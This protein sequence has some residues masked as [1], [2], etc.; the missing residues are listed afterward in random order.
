M[1]K[2]AKS[3]K[4]LQTAKELPLIIAEYYQQCHEA[5]K[6]GRPVG[7]MPPMNGAIEL[8]YAMDLQPVFPENWSP[9]CAAFGLTHQN[10]ATCENMGYS[11][12]L[13]GYLRNII[14]YVHGMMG[15]PANPLGGLPEPDII[16]PPQGGC[17][18]VMKIFQA[19]ERRFPR[20]KSFHADCPQV[21]IENIR[22]HHIDYAVGEMT[23]LVEFLT[24]ATGHR[25]DMDRLKEVV[26]LSDRACELWDEIMSFRRFIPTPISASEIGI[27]FVMVTRQGTQT[28]VDY[29]TRVRDELKE[30][31]E[32]G[33]GILEDEKVRLFWDNIPLW[34]NMGLFNYFENMGGVVVAETYSA[35]WSARLDADNPMETLAMKTLT[36]YPLV[37][38]VSIKKRKEMVLKACREYAIDGAILHRNRSCVPITLGQMDIKRELEQEGIP[39]LIIDAD[40][41]DDRN[42]STAQFQTRADAFME[43]LLRKKGFAL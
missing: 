14:G 36:S 10:F 34:Y 9:I 32:K 16:L 42:F 39:T 12:D 15:D 7:W 40:H 3:K 19:L 8:F 27:M 5:K 24:E 33:L 26:R 20:A 13:C 25:L 41:M 31:S 6:E 43:M 22:Q 4:R 35:A 18:P 28:A 29:L 11:R 38:C 2:S 17:S 1:E 21:A 23:R 30:R 37:S